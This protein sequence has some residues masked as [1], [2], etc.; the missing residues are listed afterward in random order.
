[1]V[2]QAVTRRPRSARVL[3][4]AAGAAIAVAWFVLPVA[5]F[6]FLPPRL[7]GEAE[8]L[9]SLL[10]VEAGRT[11]GEVGAGAGA[12]TVEMALRV[13]PEGRVY[14]NELSADRRAQIRAR[15]E[16]AGLANV[17][18][19]EGRPT[20]TGLPDGCCDALFLRNVYH[21]LSDVASFNA[22]LRRAVKPGGL[23][24]IIDFAPGAFWHLPGSPAGAAADRAGHGVSPR[25]VASE[26]TR[27]GFALEREI[28]NWGGRL[29]L[30]LFRA[31]S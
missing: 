17:V 20:E 7:T 13:G 15:V 2:E 11:V 26:V 31:A 14:S 24:A 9:A 30:V 22:S 28:E 21:H 25:V 5:A 19:I 8:R 16:R 12:L 10:R 4:W 29:F 27:A 1:M 3:I 18:I 6:H 23:L